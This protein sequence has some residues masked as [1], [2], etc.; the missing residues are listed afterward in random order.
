M[1]GLGE[2]LEN[3][4]KDSVDEFCGEH[5]FKDQ[6]ESA[7][8]DHKDEV[9]VEDVVQ[10]ALEDFDFSDAIHESVRDYDWWEEIEVKAKDE[11]ET[12]V[13]NARDELQS[14]VSQRFESAEFKALVREV[15]VSII[16]DAVQS[17]KD[18]ILYPFRKV[19]SAVRKRV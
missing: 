5:D 10:K 6:I 17:I 12:A 3:L 11:I 4:I 7:L 19:W 8:E 18:G 13:E 1:T 9:D 14:E 16:K 15:V 2:Q